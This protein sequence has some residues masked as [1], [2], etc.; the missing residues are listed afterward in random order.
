MR[1]SPESLTTLLYKFI[2]LSTL[3][4]V[5]FT[6][7]TSVTDNTFSKDKDKDI[8]MDLC[9]NLDIYTTKE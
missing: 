1:F 3:M 2:N 6:D 8:L 7:V 9:P 4:I 5:L